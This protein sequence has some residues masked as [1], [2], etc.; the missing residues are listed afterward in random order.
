MARSV[1]P[2]I[3]CVLLAAGH[4]AC[5][6]DNP[7]AP[8]FAPTPDAPGLACPAD[9]DVPGVT[10]SSRTIGY[11]PPALQGGYP[12]VTVSC[13]PSSGAAFPLG[14][15]LVTC[16]ARDSLD[17]QRACAFTVTL[18]PL[19]LLAAKFVAFGD[20]LTEGENG[21]EPNGPCPASARVQCLDI[22]NAYP[23]V[24]QRLLRD[25][26][27]SQTI[28]VIN[29]GI[30]G[31]RVEDDVARLPGVLSQHRPDAVLILHGFNDLRRDGEAAVTEVIGAIR[32]LIRISQQAGVQHVFVSTVLPPGDGF[33]MIEPEPILE[34]ND[35]LRQMVPAEGARLVD[36]HPL[37]VGREAMLIA[38]DGLHLTPA[39]YRVLAEAFF[40]AIE[41]SLTR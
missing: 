12:P 3:L 41:S 9:V 39:G 6:N 21:S 36:A 25:D 19:Q 1:L 26:F 34:V 35:G 8:G 14:A 15:T 5:S 2:L 27:P 23:T 33:R 4:A 10:G 11:A 20:S 30:S 13:T 7:V 22:P 37:F 24:L 38:A 32:D 18:T 16:T 40:A 17:Q 29:A 31:N 28:D